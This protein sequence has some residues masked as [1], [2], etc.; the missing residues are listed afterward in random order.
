MESQP[1][2]GI[3][4]LD[5]ARLTYQEQLVRKVMTRPL[6]ALL[7][8][9]LIHQLELIPRQRLASLLWP[10]SGDFQ[11]RTNFA[12]CATTCG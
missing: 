4:L 6:K 2:L 5:T 8:H 10:D 11:G 1:D 3:Q 7:A 12:T 9:L